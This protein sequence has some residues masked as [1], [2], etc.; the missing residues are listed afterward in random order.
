MRSRRHRSRRPAGYPASY[1]RTVVLSDGRRAHLR[2]VVPEDVEELAAAIARS[3]RETLRRRFLG[4]SPPHSP[5]DLER[6]VRVDYRRR[7]AL[8]AFDDDGTGIGIARYEGEKSWPAVELA[9]AVDPAWRGVGLGGELVTR[10]ARRAAEMGARSLTA[11]FYNDNREVQELV[12]QARL[13]E[14]RTVEAGV[15]EDE[16]LLDDRALAILAP[17]AARRRSRLLRD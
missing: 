5:A 10:V 9:V 7:F 16:L 6:L 3:D 4:G 14:R 17:P 11:D 15:V 13:P 2:P 1:E 8:A 12:R